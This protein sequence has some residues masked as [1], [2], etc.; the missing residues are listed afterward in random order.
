MRKIT[1]L[2]VIAT[3]LLMATPTQAQFSW[4]I[5][6]GVNLGSKDLAMYKDKAMV[7]NVDN[8]TGFFIGPGFRSCGNGHK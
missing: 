6:G 4:G 1:C 7:L 3:M 2:A 8:Y 5:K